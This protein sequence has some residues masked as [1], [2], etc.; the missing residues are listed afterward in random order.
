MNQ[1]ELNKI[2][3]NHRHWLYED[4]DGWEK[5]RANLTSA[6]LEAS[7]LAGTNL[8]TLCYRVL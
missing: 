7:N 6:S 4:C 2:L 3:E 8:E 1:Q 5:M